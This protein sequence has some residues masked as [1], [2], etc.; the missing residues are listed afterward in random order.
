MLALQ[1]LA[2]LLPAL[3]AGLLGVLAR[4]GHDAGATPGPTG[5]T[6][7]SSGPGAAG[8]V[9][10]LAPL[11]LVPVAVLDVLG[12]SE[13][14]AW[15][16]GRLDVVSRPLLLVAVT[17]YAGALVLSA[18]SGSAAAS[19]LTSRLLVCFTGNALVLSAV[20]VA[21]FAVGCAIVTSMVYAMI[22]GQESP[23]ARRAARTYLAFGLV[24]DAFVLAAL[25]LVVAAGGWRV[26]DAPAA[27]AASP[28]APLIVALLLLGFGEWACTF[29]LHGWLPLV[30]SGVSIPVG[31]VLSGCVIKIGL[32][33]WL[34]FLPLGEA[35]LPVWGGGLVVLALLGAGV[36]LLPGVRSNDPDASLAFSSVSQ[37]GFLGVIVGVALSAPELATACVLSAVVYAVHHGMAKGGLILTVAVWA[38][39][40]GG[41][42]R[43]WVV[44]GGV[45][46]ALAVAGAPLGS[47]AVAKYAAKSAVAAAP[48]LL[49]V[50]ALL[51]FVATATT[52]ILAR[53]AFTLRSH[54]APARQ[55]ADGWFVAWAA[56]VLG[57]TAATWYL[58]GQ[59]VP[60]VS[61]PRLDAVTVAAA[62]WPVLLGLAIAALVWYASR[63]GWL[64][65]WATDRGLPRGALEVVLDE[66]GRPRH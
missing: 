43:R 23:L 30:E 47:G 49:D 58:A 4:R 16:V 60:I 53:A 26:A 6:P 59:W 61:V 17:L 46:L 8:R 29:P 15:G 38:R 31:A 1:L 54:I 2:H 66:G 25:V 39:Y 52:L 5:V 13:P 37:M 28:L 9:A 48:F 36:A 7:S 35:A 50:T 32:V 65:S 41:P 42:Q 10:H 44:A 22:L 63:R 56:L 27:V 55:R 3:T 34:R 57:G 45:V 14:A 33:G 51:P 12:A 11:A 18:R 19:R 21:T 64:P 40:G 62:S 20:D 24:G